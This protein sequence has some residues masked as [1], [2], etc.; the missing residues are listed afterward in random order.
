MYTESRNNFS[1][2][3]VIL[4]FL[5]LALLVFI[6][7]WIFPTKKDMKKAEKSSKNNQTQTTVVNNA[8]LSIL[9]DRIFNENIMS[10]KD[11]AQSY[12]TTERLPQKVG[13]TTKITLREMLAKKIVLPFKDKN[14]DQCDLDASYVQITKH[15]NEFVMKV[16][17]KCGKE[18]NYLL[19]YMGCYDYCSKTICEK[20]GYVGKVY[21]VTPTP[22]PKKVTYYCKHVNGKYYDNNGVVV[23]KSAYEKACTAKTYYCKVVNG[24]Y[25][26]NKGKVVSKTAYEKACI[27]KPVV[28]YYCKIVNGKYY[29][30]KGNVVSKADYEKACITKP[31]VEKH[32]CEIVNGKY[33]DKKGN[34][35]SKADYEK[36]C[37]TKPVVEKHYCE[38][39]NG[40]YYDKNGKV[41]SKTA[42]EDSCYKYIYE[43]IKETKGSEK[44]S[45]WTEW[46]TKEVKASSTV[47]VQKKTTKTRKLIGYNVKVEN[48]L[49][50]PI[51]E[52][53]QVPI[54]SKEVRAC[55]QY[56]MTTTVSNYK[57]TSLGLITTK[58]SAPTSTSTVRYEKVGTYNWYCD[59]ECTSGTVYVYRM[60]QRTPVTN[61]SYSCAKYETKTSVIL[62]NRTVL[63]GYEK[64]TTKTPVYEYKETVTYRYRTKTVTPGTKT[65]KWSTYNDK[66]LL[67]AGYSYTGAYKV[68]KVTK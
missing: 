28:K 66:T 32:Y 20:K 17:L 52:T 57:E 56:S 27:T 42:Y 46:S 60:Y 33:Y 61:T 9:Y 10:M 55:T 25:Y 36:A 30:N 43:Y 51:F 41:V 31:V 54:A 65:I 40:K 34:V 5:F 1:L 21:K 37:I 14:G 53:K 16:N 19:T 39:V 24:K 68:E 6:L 44:W 7:L 50:K 3:N 49:T 4:Q 18:E 2:R 62:G 59:N 38:I 11:A 64:K 12:Y 67:S 29:D 23:S 35:V 45:E 47:E 8:D 22:V 13:D 48:D 58:L 63:T 26:D 15:D